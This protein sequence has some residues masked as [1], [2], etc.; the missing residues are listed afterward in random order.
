GPALGRLVDIEQPELL[1]RLHLGGEVHHAL[2]AGPGA[3]EH[4]AAV[5]AAVEHVGAEM[6]LAP[7]QL[8]G[9]PRAVVVLRPDAPAVQL[10]DLPRQGQADAGA[11]VAP[12]LAH[13]DL[14]ETLEEALGHLLREAGPV[15]LHHD[16][17]RV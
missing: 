6:L 11:A 16:P 2:V 15:V 3:A 14:E 12:R 4:V 7:D 1:S 9:E 5:A 8:D 10:D 17:G 13:V